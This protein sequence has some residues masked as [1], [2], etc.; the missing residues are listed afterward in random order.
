MGWPFIC[1]FTNSSSI[2]DLERNCVW[3]V[4]TEAHLFLTLACSARPFWL[5]QWLYGWRH[6]SVVRT[7]IF[8]WRTFPDLWPVYGWQVTTL[9][10]N[11]PLWGSQLCQ[12]CLPSPLGQQMSSN[13][14]MDLKTTKKGRP[15]TYDRKT[16]SVSTSFSWTSAMSETHSAS[17]ATYVAWSAT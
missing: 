4:S 5:L 8:G 7:L 10:V 3:L 1:A 13:H 17:K 11:C 9:W 12:L 2:S 14:N 15:G 6:I 16:K